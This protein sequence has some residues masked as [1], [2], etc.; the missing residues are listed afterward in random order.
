MNFVDEFERRRGW[1]EAF[2]AHSQLPRNVCRSELRRS[3]KEWSQMIWEEERKSECRKDQHQ[4]ATNL[5]NRW[6][7]RPFVNHFLL[8]LL[9]CLSVHFKQRLES[10]KV[11]LSHHRKSWRNKSYQRLPNLGP[12][13]TQDLTATTNAYS[14]RHSSECVKLFNPFEISSKMKPFDSGT[15][16]VKSRKIHFPIDQ[17]FVALF[18]HDTQDVYRFNTPSY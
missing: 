5:E 18:N 4:W 10:A 7:G 14:I 16:V 15:D 8:V 3:M 2:L 13:L 12:N 9:Y 17:R 6:K 11:F 1:K